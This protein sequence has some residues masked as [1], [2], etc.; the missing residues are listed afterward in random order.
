MRRRGL[1]SLLL[2]ADTP[3]DFRRRFFYFSRL[4]QEDQGRATAYLAAL[5]RVE[6]AETQ[7]EADIQRLEDL[8]KTL[9]Q[10]RTELGTQ[11]RQRV[12]FWQ[13]SAEAT[14]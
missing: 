1:A 3:W 10:T 13:R 6:E 8:K 11:R 2:E 9:E 5:K 12:P 7:L 14:T 4:V